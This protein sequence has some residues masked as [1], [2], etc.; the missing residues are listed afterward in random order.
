MTTI[1][2]ILFLVTLG[3]T[4]MSIYTTRQAVKESA[5]IG[6]RSDA[7]QASEQPASALRALVQEASDSGLLDE[8]KTSSDLGNLSTNFDESFEEAIRE[9]AAKIAKSTAE[10]TG[11]ISL[12]TVEMTESAKQAFDHLENYRGPVMS[13]M[14]EVKGDKFEVN[15]EIQKNLENILI[16][17]FIEGKIPI[18][19]VSQGKSKEFFDIQRFFSFP[20][21]RFSSRHVEAISNTLFEQYLKTVLELNFAR[22]IVESSK[23]HARKLLES[24]SASGTKEQG[25]SVQ[26]LLET[27]EKTATESK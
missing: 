25:K 19:P 5:G 21:S 6:L 15:P 18:L 2:V 22:Q 17:E 16:T 4:L 3:L 14:Y 1:I 26:R 27:M 13:I 20:K 11:E 10:R 8:Q 9:T 7:K 23:K 24:V 12:M